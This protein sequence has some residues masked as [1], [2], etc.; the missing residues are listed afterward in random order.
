MNNLGYNSLYVLYKYENDIR[1]INTLYGHVKV[2]ESIPLEI[3]KLIKNPIKFYNEF[4]DPDYEPFI[5]ELNLNKELH[6][7]LIQE[8]INNNS[9]NLENKNISLNYI[10][11]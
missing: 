5:L 10:T 3:T 9:I 8:Y 4:I 1:I 2:Y 7:N 6:K 11:K